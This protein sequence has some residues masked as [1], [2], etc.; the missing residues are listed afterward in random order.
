MP[1]QAGIACIDAFRRYAEDTKESPTPN[2]ARKLCAPATVGVDS[3]TLINLCN[4]QHVST[5]RV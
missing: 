3:S 4:W 2:R 1:H 5:N